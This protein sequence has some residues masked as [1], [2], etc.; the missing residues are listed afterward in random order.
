VCKKETT[1]RKKLDI[2]TVKIKLAKEL[3][4]PNQQEVV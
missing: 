4:D 3:K 2:L 1:R